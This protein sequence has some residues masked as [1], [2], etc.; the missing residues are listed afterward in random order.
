MNCKILGCMYMD[1]RARK[2]RIKDEEKT[3]EAMEGES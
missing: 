1:N 2:D 3:K